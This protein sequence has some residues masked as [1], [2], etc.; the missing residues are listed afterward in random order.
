MSTWAPIRYRG[1][2]DVPRV[3]ITPHN[4]RTYLFDCP[5]DEELEDY[6]DS[7]RVYTMPDLLVEELPTDW[8]TLY[9]RA[10]G[11][12]GEIPVAR[13]RF[14]PTRRREIDSSVLDELTGATR[15]S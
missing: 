15:I 13:V 6:I 7:Y 5:F 9:Q 1:F 2:W 4:G 12:L 14:D 11:F 3:F 8:T 10:T